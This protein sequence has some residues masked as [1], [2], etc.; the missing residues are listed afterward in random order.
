MI[1]SS[2][3]SARD[4]ACCESRWH[5]ADHSLNHII[6]G[7]LG[8]EEVIIGACHDGAVYAYYTNAIENS[9]HLSGEPPNPSVNINPLSDCC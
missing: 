7:L 6:V 1:L 5:R 2:P 3:Q 4:K 9:L 8:D